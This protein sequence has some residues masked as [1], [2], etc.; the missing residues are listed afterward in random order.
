MSCGCCG[1]GA[2]QGCPNPAGCSK[3]RFGCGKPRFGCSKL[4][5]PPD[6]PEKRLR[7]RAPEALFG[8]VRGG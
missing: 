5:R 4:G 3:P 6:P 2:C 1:G 8:G 7:R